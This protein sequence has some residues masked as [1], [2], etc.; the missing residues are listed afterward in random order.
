MIAKVPLIF[1]LGLSLHL[2]AMECDAIRTIPVRLFI[3]AAAPPKIVLAAQNEAAWVL[4]SLCVEIEWVRSPSTQAL[5]I[6]IIAAPLPHSTSALALGL[7]TLNPKHNARATVFFSRVRETWL[8][9][10]SLIR[11]DVL[12]GCVIAHEIGHMLLSTTAHSSDGVM[13]AHFGKN[14]VLRAAQRRLLFTRFDR[15]T[16]SRSQITPRIYDSTIAAKR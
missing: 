9:Y 7:T 11:L 16:F 2:G 15:E 13:V 12:L 8:P 10:S 3:D 5:E 4:R 6:R 1:V 14:E